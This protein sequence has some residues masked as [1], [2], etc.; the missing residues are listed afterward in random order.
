MKISV[1]GH[2]QISPRQYLLWKKVNDLG[3][4]EVQ[5]LAPERWREEVADPKYVTPVE[6]LY[7]GDIQRYMMIVEGKIID[8]KP[9]WIVSMTEQWRQQTFI[10]YQ[11]A[12]WQGIKFA[13]FRWENIRIDDSLSEPMRMIQRLVL[14]N[15][16]L[17][18]CG[19]KE[20]EEITKSQSKQPTVRLLET[21][22][23]T[24]TFKPVNVKKKFDVL[25]VGRQTPEKG[26]NTIKKACEG[27][28]LHIND[29]NTP[30]DKLPELMSSARVGVVGSIDQ[31]GW[32][33][34]CCFVIGEMLACG[35]PV[36][37]TNAGSIPE[38]WGDVVWV[39]P[40]NDAE[41]MR[42]AILAEISRVN[43]ETAKDFARYSPVWVQEH[44]SNERLAHAYVEALS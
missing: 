24:D 29:G 5:V 16:D 15:A 28:N 17:L 38:I 14:D 36:V 37:S 25:Y 9:D 10:N 4:A 3:L 41:I 8:F 18:I 40:Q 39:V 21:G 2:D 31:P 34:Q 32:K 1:I 11:I 30:Y 42:R 27:L 35:L 7:A 44:Y 23:D 12:K 33:E 22:I 43:S 13:C 20:A 6:T 26:L 19:N